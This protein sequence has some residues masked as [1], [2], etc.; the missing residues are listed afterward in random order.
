MRK[1]D[2]SKSYH[3]KTALLAGRFWPGESVSLQRVWF[4]RRQ[5]L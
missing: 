3:L 4:K 5:V 1:E 2:M